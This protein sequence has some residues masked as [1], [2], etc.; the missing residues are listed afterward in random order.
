V[1]GDPLA[2]QKRPTAARTYR[3]PLPETIWIWRN[4]GRIRDRPR[5]TQCQ[6]WLLAPLGSPPGGPLLG[7]LPHDLAFRQMYL[8]GPQATDLETSPWS[9]S[10]H[11]PG[12]RKGRDWLR[13]TQC[14]HWLWTPLASAQFRTSGPWSVRCRTLKPP[15]S[16][17]RAMRLE[18]A[19]PAFRETQKAGGRRRMRKGPRPFERA[20]GRTGLIGA[21]MSAPAPDASTVD[22]IGLRQVP[23]LVANVEG[24][25]ES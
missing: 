25:N 10:F 24:F 5:G 17:L 2:A 15:P 18:L 13:G 11:W 8:F 19:Q 22:H 9:L 14:Q 1:F 16:L 3:R 21:L 20:P 7:G 4:K 23:A 12:G 6:C